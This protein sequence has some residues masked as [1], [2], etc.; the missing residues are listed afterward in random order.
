L[1]TYISFKNEGTLPANGQITVKLD[2]NYQFIE[3]IPSPTSIIGTDSLVWDYSQLSLFS[4][5]N[6]RIK[7][8]VKQTTPLGS[9]LKMRGHIT[10][11]VPDFSPINNDF[12]LEDTVVGSYD[13]NEKRVS[14]AQGLT[15]N[16]IANGKELI[17]TINFQNTGTFEADRVRITDQLD[18]TLNME[19]LR[20]VAASHEVSNFRLLPGNLLEVDFQHIA[21]PDSNVNEAGSHGFVT[22]AIQKNKSYNPSYRIY[23]KAAIYFDFNEPII[24]N[25][26][27][28]RVIPS[29][30]ATFEPIKDTK[31]DVFLQIS[32]NPT[33]ERCVI[34]T[35]G[36][37]TGAGEIIIVNEIG[38]IFYQTSISDLSRPISLDVSKLGNGLY[39]VNAKGEKGIMVG[40]LVVER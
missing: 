9:L 16:E 27:V 1:N 22:F 32:P 29:I 30:V 7:G 20:L 6:I 31:N 21:L 28:T 23:N 12:M 24:T 5:D 18:T 11:N 8:K 26:V 14:P 10:T 4:Q 39:L 37:L 40:K 36:K 34:E 3:A 25:Q 13:P 38:Q 35:L 2:P 17:Y 33:T 15:S 19:T